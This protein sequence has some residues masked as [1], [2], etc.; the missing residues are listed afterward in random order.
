MIFNPGNHKI[1]KIAVQ[2]IK[3]LIIQL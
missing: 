3:G 2:T 1:L